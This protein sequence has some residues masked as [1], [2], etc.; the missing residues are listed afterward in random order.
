MEPL[1]LARIIGR[2]R[3]EL[4]EIPPPLSVFSGSGVA[5]LPRR[6]GIKDAV[7]VW[8]ELSATGK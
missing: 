6:V 5:V 8:R 7:L 3:G 2:T 1:A 4:R